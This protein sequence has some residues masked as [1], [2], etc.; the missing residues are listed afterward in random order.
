MLSYSFFLLLLQRRFVLFS[1]PRLLELVLEY[2]DE[3]VVFCFLTVQ[4]SFFS[5]DV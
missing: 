3:L 5:R 2:N 1:F 4:I